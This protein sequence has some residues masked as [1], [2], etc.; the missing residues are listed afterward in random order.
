MKNA[1]Q[2]SLLCFFYVRLSHFLAM[3]G[4]D[5]RILEPGASLGE[6][7]DAQSATRTALGRRN[8]ARRPA[9][10]AKKK[11]QAD[12]MNAGSHFSTEKCTTNENK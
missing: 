4:P 10:M 1:I 9:Q 12:H 7:R 3:G 8:L 11:R 6:P 5:C 2:R